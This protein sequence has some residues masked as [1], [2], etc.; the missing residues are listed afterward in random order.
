MSDHSPEPGSDAGTDDLQADIERTREQLGNT[1]DALTQKLDVKSRAKEGV[2]EAKDSA[3]EAVGNA[4][5]KISDATSAVAGSD[6][7]Q[8]VRE[9]PV[10][11]AVVAGVVLVAVVAFVVWRKRVA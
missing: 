6:A 3:A 1:V 9:R 7:V 4:R 5:H 8:G 10:V 11:P 2:G